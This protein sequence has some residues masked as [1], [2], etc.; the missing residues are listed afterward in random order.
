MA[1][2]RKFLPLNTNTNIPDLHNNDAARNF[3][4]SDFFIHDGSYLRLKELR[5]TYTFP[6]EI[7]SKL[8]LSNLALSLTGYNLLT[9]TSYN[10]FDP[11]VGKVIGSESNNLSMGVDHG[12]YPQSRSF[13]F[14]I[15]LG[16]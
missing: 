12:N 9:F 6:Q 3:R 4:A 1:D 8:K 11:E 2:N 10:G 15:K 14:G 7:I 16:L 13:T 5:I